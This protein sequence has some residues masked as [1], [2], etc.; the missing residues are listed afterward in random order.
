MQTKIWEAHILAKCNFHFSHC[1]LYSEAKILVLQKTNDAVCLVN[2]VCTLAQDAVDLLANLHNACLQRKSGRWNERTLVLPLPLR[3]DSLM[4]YESAC[5]ILTSQ[6]IFGSTM[7]LTLCFA[8]LIHVQNCAGSSSPRPP[9]SKC[10]KTLQ[11]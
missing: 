8:R 10:A 9:L 2:A 3:V 6:F 5:T 1:R 4:N 7:I 11:T